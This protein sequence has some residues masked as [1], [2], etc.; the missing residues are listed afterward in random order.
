MHAKGEN[1]IK[2]LIA[3]DT[4]SILKENSLIVWQKEN[5]LSRRIFISE[6]KAAKE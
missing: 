2:T 1:L 4:Y 3:A 6:S 5:R